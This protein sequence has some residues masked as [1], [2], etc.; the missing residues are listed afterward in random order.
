MEP[1][2]VIKLGGAALR[3][4]SRIQALC[5][6]LGRV[7]AHGLPL[8]VVHGGGPSINAELELHGIGWS[9]IEGQ[10]IT[11]PA[12]MDIVE[13]VLCGSVN[14]RLVR[15]LGASGA[16]AVGLSGADAGLLRCSP[17]SDV[18]GQVGRIERVDTCWLWQLLR[19]DV[20]PVI[21]PTGV[22]EDGASFNINA[23]WAAAAIA[24][25]LGAAKLLFVT[26]QDGILDAGKAVVPELCPV[27]L[28]ELIAQGAIQGGMLAKTRALLHALRSG[29]DE[30]QVVNGAVPGNISAALIE[31]LPAGTVCRENAGPLAR[32]RQPHFQT[33]E[34]R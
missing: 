21:A 15:A 24:G 14:P 31:E 18:L 6:E 29:V 33:G 8:V 10:R 19:L 34:L 32:T 11:P 9:F 13:M 3:E 22:G 30:I 17:V 16:R 12:A 20:V 27:E 23:D 2:T 28:E 25:A 1:L 26:D 5:A 4:P 7:R